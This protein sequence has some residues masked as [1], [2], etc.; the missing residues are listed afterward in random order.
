MSWSADALSG[1][2]RFQPGEG[3]GWPWIDEGDAG[4]RLEDG[5]GDDSRTAEEVQIDEVHSRR[6]SAHV[7]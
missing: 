3:G 2:L 7:R 6:Q 4:R 1:Q 5:G